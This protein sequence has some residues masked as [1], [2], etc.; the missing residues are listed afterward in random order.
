MQKILSM[1]Q[2]SLLKCFFS[3]FIFLFLGV[4]VEDE[5]PSCLSITVLRSSLLPPPF[6][7]C[8]HLCTFPLKRRQSLH[9]KV[10]GT[11][12]CF[13]FV[14][15]VD[16]PTKGIRQTQGDNKHQAGNRQSRLY[17]TNIGLTSLIMSCTNQENCDSVT[18][19]QYLFKRCEIVSLVGLNLQPC[20]CRSCSLTT[21]PWWQLVLNPLGRLLLL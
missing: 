4:G 20:D 15:I 21:G 6:K 10:E 7:L 2:C 19:W 18:R 16:L 13:L 8:P 11:W 3:L 17:Y 9:L 5:D 12:D 14:W 1:K